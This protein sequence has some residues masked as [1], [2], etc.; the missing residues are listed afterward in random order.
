MNSFTELDETLKSQQLQQQN[1]QKHVD[2]EIEKMLSLAEKKTEMVKRFS[3]ADAVA[4]QMNQ[5][6]N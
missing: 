5:E 2:S 3:L 6:A 1:H 4:F